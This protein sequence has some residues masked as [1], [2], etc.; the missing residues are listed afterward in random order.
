LIARAVRQNAPKARKLASVKSTCPSCHLTGVELYKDPRELPRGRHRIDGV[1]CNVRQAKALALKN[2]WLPVPYRP[3][4]EVALDRL[5]IDNAAVALMSESPT[6]RLPPIA[7]Y[8]REHAKAW[9][10]ATSALLT[11]SYDARSDVRIIPTHLHYVPPVVAGC[12]LRAAAHTPEKWILLVSGAYGASQEE[13]SAIE[14]MLALGADVSSELSDLI[15]RFARA[16][17]R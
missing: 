14:V 8:W 10:E 16:D 3:A 13:I 6:G 9:Y 12:A 2:G 4:L 15:S 7:Q 11:I 17:A 1:E 5:K